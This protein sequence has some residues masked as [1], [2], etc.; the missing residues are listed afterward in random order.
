M[1]LTLHDLHVDL[2]HTRIERAFPLL[3]ALTCCYS[4]GCLYYSFQPLPKTQKK[5]FSYVRLWNAFMCGT[6]IVLLQLFDQE[7]GVKLYVVTKPLEFIDTWLLMLQGKPLSRIHCVH[8]ALTT[9]YAWTLLY[10]EVKQGTFMAFLNLWVHVVMY[11][12][13]FWVSFYPWF[14]QISWMVTIAQILQF[15]VVMMYLPFMNLSWTCFVCTLGMYLY[16]LVEFILIFKNKVP[17]KKQILCVNC[18]VTTKTKCVICRQWT[19][20]DCRV[21][22]AGYCK[23]CDVKEKE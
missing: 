8:H 23:V 15:I 5:Y 6:S 21:P 7:I 13:Y 2:S 3:L 19:C 20:M 11:A 18:N 4:V 9:I 12:Y 1:N 10:Y 14:R 22:G 17:F 16:Y